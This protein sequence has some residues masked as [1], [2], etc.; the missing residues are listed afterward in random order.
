MPTDALLI[1]GQDAE[2]GEHPADIA[3][4]RDLRTVVMVNGVL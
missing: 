2:D 1:T 4:P 3:V